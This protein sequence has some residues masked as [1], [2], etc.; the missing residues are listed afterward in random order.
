MVIPCLIRSPASAEIVVVSDGDVAGPSNLPPDEPEEA[1]LPRSS[2]GDARRRLVLADDEDDNDIED[3]DQAEDHATWAQASPPGPTV[4]ADRSEGSDEQAGAA[5]SA[6]CK[7]AQVIVSSSEEEQQAAPRKGRHASSAG[8]QQP[9]CRKPAG[10]PRYV[11]PAKRQ[12]GRRAEDALKQAAASFQASPSRP[13]Q[14]ALSPAATPERQSALGT[15]EYSSSPSR[16]PQ[17]YFMARPQDGHEGH[18]KPSELGSHAP[19]IGTDLGA[20]LRQA[21]GSDAMQRLASLALP[22]RQ[23]DG[24]LGLD[25]NGE[26][27]DM[28]TERSASLAGADGEDAVQQMALAAA[29]A[30]REA[31][32]AMSY[33]D[34]SP[35]SPGTAADAQQH[36]QQS[37]DPEAVHREQ[38]AGDVD[39]PGHAT[40]GS[41][42]PMTAI[43]PALAPA[44]SGRLSA[45][46]QTPAKQR[47]GRTSQT[48]TP[49]QT[50]GASQGSKAKAA[51]SK[52]TST[53]TKGLDSVSGQKGILSYFSPRS[54][55]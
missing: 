5:A 31:L 41:A 10:Q 43:E 46:A 8:Q 28:T 37:A 1:A 22:G 15:P 51:M 30:S 52:G 55:I 47:S 2:S 24:H 29:A 53:E 45:P 33:L 36:F 42:A 3:A 17:P 27:A 16:R 54:K 13:G 18:A 50:R 21:Q 39:S 19:G 32:A 34:D 38:A 25:E 40:P 12:S 35:R 9:R 4:V 20:L 26:G 23:A 11:P 6:R 7:A 14:A 44:R 49:R 48:S